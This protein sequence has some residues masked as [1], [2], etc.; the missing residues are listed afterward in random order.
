MVR[1]FSGR[2]SPG[3]GERTVQQWG[4]GEWSYAENL[5]LGPLLPPAYY[6]EGGETL[7]FSLYNYVWLVLFFMLFIGLAL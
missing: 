1:L 7:M 4:S 2:D 5:N 6:D 3:H